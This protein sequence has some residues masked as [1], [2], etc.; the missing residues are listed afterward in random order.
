MRSRLDEIKATDGYVDIPRDGPPGLSPPRKPSTNGKAAKSKASSGRFQVL[1]TFCDESAR[2]VSNAAVACWMILFR[3]TKPDG[4]A[5]VAYSQ[6]AECLGIKRR[7]AMRLVQDLVDA[8][9]V[10]VVKRGTMKGHTPSTYKIHA[11]PKQRAN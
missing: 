1:N 6:I 2:L 3:E 7:A 10:T 8:G 4:L 11:T 5:T 9:L